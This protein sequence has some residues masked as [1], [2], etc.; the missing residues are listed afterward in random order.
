MRKTV[1]ASAQSD[2][3]QFFS[4]SFITKKRWLLGRKSRILYICSNQFQIQISMVHFV[5]ANRWWHSSGFLIV[6]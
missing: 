3:N 4:L 5:S 1:E 6:G 2:V